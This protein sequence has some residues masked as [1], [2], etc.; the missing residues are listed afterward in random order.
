LGKNEKNEVRKK[1][2]EKLFP[3]A[4]DKELEFPEHHRL[5]SDAFS[6]A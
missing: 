2:G 5:L 1:G 3:S 4:N 6:V